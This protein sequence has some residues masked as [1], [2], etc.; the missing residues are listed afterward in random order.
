M[1]TAI[2]KENIITHTHLSGNLLSDTASCTCSA[3]VRPP[4][5]KTPVVSTKVRLK[6]M[7]ENSKNIKDQLSFFSGHSYYSIASINISFENTSIISIHKNLK[8]F[9]PKEIDHRL[10]AEVKK[11]IGN[12][13]LRRLLLILIQRYIDLY[14]LGVN[15]KEEIDQQL[16]ATHLLRDNI[17]QY[18]HDKWTGQSGFIIAS[19]VGAFLTTVDIALFNSKQ[20]TPISSTEIEEK[21][22]RLIKRRLDV[23]S[24]RASYNIWAARY[25]MTSSEIEISEDEEIVFEKIL[26][27]LAEVMVSI[28]YYD[29]QVLDGKYEV[30][31]STDI[32]ENIF[33]ANILKGVTYSYIDE[34]ISDINLKAKVLNT[35]RKIFSG[36]NLDNTLIRSL[37]FILKIMI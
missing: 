12:K 20:E 28:M 27:F 9:L 30:N 1:S 23:P 21:V 25:L 17:Y 36:V 37:M 29:N 2:G 35:A 16:I 4:K 3:C 7:K 26:P 8:Q 15:Q 24:V 18:I 34:N 31:S 11:G 13:K 5:K 10:Q 32:F 14:S 19:C 22:L 6:A 33:C